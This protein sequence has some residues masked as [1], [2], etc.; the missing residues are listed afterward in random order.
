MCVRPALM[1]RWIVLAAVLVLGG[2]AVTSDRDFA[3]HLDKLTFEELCDTWWQTHR[4]WDTRDPRD[5]AMLDAFARRGKFLSDC[6]GPDPWPGR[7]APLPP[8]V[9]RMEPVASAED[10]AAA[11]A[12]ATAGEGLRESASFIFIAPVVGSLFAL[13]G[14]PLSLI[15]AQTQY[16]KE[17]SGGCPE[18]LRE[19]LV[20]VP[21]WVQSTFAGAPVAEL[22]AQ[23][24]RS[25]L[26]D[27]GPDIVVLHGAGSTKERLAQHERLMKDRG[28]K[29]LILADVSVVLRDVAR[30]SDCDL[31]LVSEARIRV[32][33]I[34]KPETKEPRYSVRAETPQVS[35]EQWAAEP[36][37][38]RAQLDELLAALGR[39]LIWSY[40][41]RMGCSDRGCDWETG[42]P[43]PDRAAPV[44]CLVDVDATAVRCDFTDHESCMSARPDQ[45]YGC[46]ESGPH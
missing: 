24:A 27:G 42:R 3:E 33:R 8:I 30:G 2:C 31:K 6:P 17:T 5:R 41:D 22:V 29:A 46:V 40:G 28:V 37:R 11:R 9:V 20:D 36:A 16:L 39:N 43:S 1:L 4:Y 14:I 25:Q 34:G 15:D 12:M 7:E 45:R 44:W 38:A 13:G 10:Y 18:R 32:Q 19:R 21:A 23:G 26:R 35:L